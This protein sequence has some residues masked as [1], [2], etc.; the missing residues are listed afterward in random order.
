[1]SY[2]KFELKGTRFWKNRFDDLKFFDIVPFED[3]LDRVY[4]TFCDFGKFFSGGTFIYYDEKYLSHPKMKSLYKKYNINTDDDSEMNQNNQICFYPYGRNPFEYK[5][6]AK[7]IG[8]TSNYQVRDG[9]IKSPFE[10]LDLHY[11]HYMWL[12]T[13]NPKQ[14]QLITNDYLYFSIPNDLIRTYQER[15][16]NNWN[17]EIPSKFIS[18]VNDWDDVESIDKLI[19]EYDSKFENWNHDFPIWAFRSILQDGLVM[20]STN[21]A[22]RKFLAA[23]T[24]RLFM[25]GQ[26]GNDYPIFTQIPFNKTKW[27]VTSPGDI[28]RNE[29]YLS[30]NIDLEVKKIEFYLHYSQKWPSILGEPEKIGYIEL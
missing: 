27:S 28:F 5:Y 30:A 22:L 7:L 2:E 4:N 17:M 6:N 3:V 29:K 1:M 14:R 8:S 9:A 20:P 24:H 13:D 25:C 18:E 10:M 21:F 16:N 19:D 15:T 12:G 23:G 26:S 11:N